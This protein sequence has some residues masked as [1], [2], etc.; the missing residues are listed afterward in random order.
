MNDEVDVC[1]FSGL[2]CCM[3]LPQDVYSDPTSLTGLGKCEMWLISS[4][5]VGEEDDM[6]K[7]WIIHCVCTRDQDEKAERKWAY[8]PLRV[9]TS[10]LCLP[11][12]FPS[13]NSSSFLNGNRLITL[14]DFSGA[15][16]SFPASQALIHHLLSFSSLIKWAESLSEVRKG[17]QQLPI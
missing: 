17:P 16:A 11:G 8:L 3:S 15:L 7:P 13:K 2:Y 4:S 14:C 10:L 6:K 1:T 9:Y 5:Q 12:K